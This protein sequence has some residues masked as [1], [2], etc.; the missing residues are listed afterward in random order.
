MVATL[1]R[2][3]KLGHRA[4]SCRGCWNLGHELRNLALIFWPQSDGTSQ[5]WTEISETVVNPNKLFLPSQK[6]EIR[7]LI[8]GIFTWSEHLACAT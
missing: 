8:S 6:K 7:V 2:E 4:H 5:P 3:K 1:R